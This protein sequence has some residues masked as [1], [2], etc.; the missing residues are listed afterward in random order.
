MYVGGGGGRDVVTIRTS[1]MTPYWLQY[2]VCRPVLASGAEVTNA[3]HSYNAC[4][5]MR[6]LNNNGYEHRL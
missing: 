3:F 6:A 5:Y 1:T 4:W 2:H